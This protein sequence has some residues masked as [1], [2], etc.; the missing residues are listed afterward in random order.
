MRAPALLFSL[1]AVALGC[2]APGVPAA[3]GAPALRPTARVSSTIRFRAGYPATL[4]YALDAAAGERNR[5]AGY[6]AWFGADATAPWLAA[7]RERRR[8]WGEPVRPDHG[9]GA[10]AFEVCA[11]EAATLEEAI[12]CI[13]GVVP[14][15]ERPLA[16]AAIRAA[17]Q[18]LAPRWPELSAPLIAMQPALERE[19][20]AARAAAL[21]RTLHRE[22]RLADDAALQFNVVLVAKPAGPHAYARQAGQ[23][24]VHEVGPDETVGA[25]LA[26]AF[27]ET[28]HLAHSM[29]PRRAAM[30]RA[31]LGHGDSRLLA[32][33]V[34]DEVVA[35]A[36]GNG[37]AAAQLD[38]AFRVDRAFYSDPWIDALGRALFREWQAGLDVRLGPELAAHLVQLVDREWPVDQRPLARY[39]WYVTIHVQDRALGR[40]ALRGVAYRSAARFSP[41]EDELPAGPDLPPWAPRLVLVTVDELVQ[42][43][44]LAARVAMP[45]ASW[46]EALAAGPAAVYRH[47]DDAGGPV[48]VVVGRDVPALQAAV[49]AFVGLPR[50][51]APGWSALPASAVGP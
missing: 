5:D 7:Y 48:F 31:F 18:Q 15:P 44:A 11:W 46:N 45:P 35:T 36:F 38:P 27:H 17:D 47:D 50:M 26:V 10:P 14:E 12:R 22:A 40:E 13:E 33:T 30:E 23:Y 34:W 3:T 8:S 9:G 37:L 41:I 42:R 24:L 20:G 2:A 39:L 32:A 4:L 21:L 1:A 51:V 28:A 19:L 43:P 29:S 16:V 6:R 49:A 25:L